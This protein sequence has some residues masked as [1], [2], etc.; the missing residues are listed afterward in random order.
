[1]GG[2][3]GGGGYDVV[4]KRVCCVRMRMNCNESAPSP[5]LLS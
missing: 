4:R 3:G 2:G 5:Q 1:V